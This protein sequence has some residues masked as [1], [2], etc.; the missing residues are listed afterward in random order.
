[1]MLTVIHDTLQKYEA[2]TDQDTDQD[3]QPQVRKILEILGNK[4]LSAAEI[5]GH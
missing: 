3:V 5:M 4:T 2:V 1:M